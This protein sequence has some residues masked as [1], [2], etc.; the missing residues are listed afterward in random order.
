[1]NQSELRQKVE[2]QQADDLPFIA[3]HSTAESDV[4]IELVDYFLQQLIGKVTVDRFQLLNMEQMWEELLHLS[5]TKDCGS[6]SRHWR[7]TV[8]VIDWKMKKNDGSTAVRSCCFRRE[9]LLAVYD[10]LLAK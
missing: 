2:Q 9:G 1:M 7:K 4:R 5:E 8:E 6:F 3:W 10:E